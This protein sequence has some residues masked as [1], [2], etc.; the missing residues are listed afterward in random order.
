MKNYCV[1][2]H[3]SPSN[4][5]YVGISCDA[6]KRWNEGRGYS[7]NYIFYRAIRKYGW[8]NIK[9]EI[10]YDGLTLEEAKE[11][12]SKLISEWNLTD[13]KYG[14]NL[15]SLKDGLCEESKMLMSLSRIGNN[16]CEGRVLSSETKQKIS[17]SLKKYYS[18]DSNREQLHRPCSD[19]TKEKLRKRMFSEETRAK[20]RKNHYDFSKGKNPSAKAVRQLSLSGELIKEYE[21]A[22]LAATELNID[23]SSIIKCCRGKKKTCGGFRWEYK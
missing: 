8:D 16:N 22:K 9:H 3:T 20:M 14:Y 10:L 2:C 11:I 5:K 4:R 17:C 15:S 23:L 13:R 12:E 18:V 19:E 1:Y 6:K 21:Y 7:K